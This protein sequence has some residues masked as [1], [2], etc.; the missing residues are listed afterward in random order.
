[1]NVKIDDIKT[2]YL[3]KTSYM[4]DDKEEYKKN[5]LYDK[6]AQD[7]LKNISNIVS[8][9]ECIKFDTEIER[10]GLAYK[11][12]IN[13][14][15]ENDYIEINFIYFYQHKSGGTHAQNIDFVVKRNARIQIY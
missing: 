11:Y 12:L 3:C 5:D 9:K 4:Y 2:L 1:M 7:V 10:E 6:D 15:N 14:Y 13:G 8:N